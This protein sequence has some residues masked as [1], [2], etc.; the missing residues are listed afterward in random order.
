VD[1]APTVREPSI[2]TDRVAA[3]VV[4]AAIEVHRELGPGLLEDHYKDALEIELGLRG[5]RVERE[6]RV[7]IAYKGHPF[8]RHY[9]MDFVVDGR[10]IVEA[11]AQTMTLAV[12]RAQTLSYLK[13]TGLE[14]GFLLNFHAPLMKHGITRLANTALAPWRPGGDEGEAP[15]DNGR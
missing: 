12:H 6:V 8:R 2:D 13:T 14:V 9:A 11:K 7:P 15:P 4:A 3:D 10:V 5:R 1:H